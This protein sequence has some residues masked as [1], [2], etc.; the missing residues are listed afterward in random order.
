MRGVSASTEGE[1]LGPNRESSKEPA[2]VL[3]RL[4]VA[5]SLGLL[6]PVFPDAAYSLTV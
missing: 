6:M 3:A 5:R 1:S 4:N 2:G